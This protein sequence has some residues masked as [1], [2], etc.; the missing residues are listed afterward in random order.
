MSFSF[1]ST[2]YVG[3]GNYWKNDLA[4]PIF[5]P[6]ANLSG[7]NSFQIDVSNENTM[8]LA[9][10]IHNTCVSYGDFTLASGAKSDFYVDMRLF[11]FSS[12]VSLLFKPLLDRVLV[13]DF[14]AI[15]GPALG[16]VP[17]ATMF[18]ATLSNIDKRGFAVRKDTKEHGK[19][20]LIEGPVK[21]GDRVIVLEDV[22]TTGGSGLHA[23]KALRD[24]GCEVL[25]VIT[26]VD[27]MQGG[28][29]LY[30]EN[31][32]PFD[33][34]FTIDEILACKSHH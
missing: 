23:V 18:L 6:L 29:E 1:S 28:A 16:A 13:H 14:D 20:N 24:Y 9:Q 33:R 10:E 26:V 15:G 21:K 7:P 27:R 30:A 3:M 17:I 32:V 22:T 19:Q 11:T 34:I 31:D 12:K 8:N 5:G 4:Y 25:K 2:P